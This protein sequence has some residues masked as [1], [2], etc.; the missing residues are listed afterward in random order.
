MTNLFPKLK[1]AEDVVRAA[2]KKPIFRR[3]FDR[4]YV[5]VSQT[6]VKSAWQ[7]FYHNFLWP[8][9]KTTLENVCVSDM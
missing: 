5:K 3:P 6:L 2:S 4:Q 7:H 8:W 9:E 1:P